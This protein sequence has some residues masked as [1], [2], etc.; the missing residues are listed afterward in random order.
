[1]IA[2]WALLA[3]F[4]SPAAGQEIDKKK[5][6]ETLQ[7]PT[8]NLNVKYG[9]SPTT[10]LIDLGNE[11]DKKKEIATLQQK[12]QSKADAAEL[13]YELAVLFEDD[14]NIAESKK[15]IARAVE[16]YR[17]KIKAEPGNARLLAELGLS[18]WNPEEAKEAEALLRQAVTLAPQDWKCW[19]SLGLFY[20][21]GFAGFVDSTGKRISF[22]N[23]ES[24]YE[25]AA[26]GKVDPNSA[27]DAQRRFD[28]ALACLDKAVEVAPGEWQ[29]YQ[30]RAG[31]RHMIYLLG[32]A[33]K[34]ALGEKEPWPKARCPVSPEVIA[35]LNKAAELKPSDPGL[36][37]V[38]VYYHLTYLMATADLAPASSPEAFWKK[39]P[40]KDRPILLNHVQRLHKIASD[41]DVDSA[42][43]ASEF[44][45]FLNVIF[46]KD[47]DNGSKYLKRALALN[48]KLHRAWEILSFAFIFQ[49]KWDEA[50]KVCQQRIQL[51][52]T[53]R[54][55]YLLAKVHAENGN[56]Q[57]V[58]AT[59]TAGLQADPDD[60]NCNLG[61][62]VAYLKHED[63]DNATWKA[64][65]LM[66]KS[67]S[68]I[69]D[70]PDRERAW[71]VLLVGAAYNALHADRQMAIQQITEADQ[72]YPD[73]PYG[74][75]L[76][77]IIGR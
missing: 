72:L 48:P 12:L 14:G 37:G 24:L 11:R 30:Q 23:L 27:R 20:S 19:Q 44:L 50:I 74:K 58:E 49:E 41:P 2:G 34:M 28:Q 29:P 51:E 9:I 42:C 16:L 73:D 56:W 66:K 39:V 7:L 6:R 55:Y 53:P 61:L 5:L 52:P 75:R 26:G 38:T 36:V 17:Q 33:L 3:V 10:G 40:D 59:L 69:G 65:E 63:D 32:P 77:E 4:A 46:V 21:Q 76:A 31:L 1:M 62:A 43:A 57:S 70:P 68:K 8:V 64:L 13:Y 15:A 67:T 18:L 54:N 47:M 35:D 25:L 22:D 45:G 71:G 60:F